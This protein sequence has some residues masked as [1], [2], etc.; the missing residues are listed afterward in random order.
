M[1]SPGN[2]LLLEMNLLRRAT[3]ETVRQLGLNVPTAVIVILAIGFTV[4]IVRTLS[5]PE[6]DS[7]TGF[8]LWLIK[9]I[10]WLSAVV[11]VFVPNFAWNTLTVARRDRSAAA[12]L[13]MT[14]ANDAFL[15][16]R[17]KSFL[18]NTL[19]NPWYGVAECYAFGSV[20]RLH[21]TR[22]VDIVV[23]FDSSD[24]RQVRLYRDRLR[25]IERLFHEHHTLKLHVQTFLSAENEYRRRFL[26][27]AGAHERIV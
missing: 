23:Q 10:G 15:D 19:T 2:Y 9:S 20:V 1:E 11:V 12:H 22:D 26:N 18:R 3:N 25:K 5:A 21:P 4:L 13:K 17:M 7:V 24:P 16:D 27:D 6:T 8:A 14:T